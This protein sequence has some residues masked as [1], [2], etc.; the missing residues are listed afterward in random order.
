MLKYAKAVLF[1]LDGTLVDSMWMWKDIDMEYLGKYGITLPPELQ[2]YIEG[3]SFSEVSAYFKE[4]FG[5]KESLEEIKSEWV[6][7][8]KYKYTHEVPLK[9]GALRFL[10]HLKE[11]GIPMGIATSNSRDLLDAVLESLE[12]SP[13]FD[14]CMTSCEAGAGKPAPDI[15]LKVAKILKTEPKDCLIFEDTPAGILAGNRAGIPVC[16][17]ADENSAGRKE[18][19]LQMADYYAETFDQVLDRTYRNLKSSAAK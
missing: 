6:S 16:A 14:C 4:A 13:Y 9:P 11:Q 17:M 3:M 15:Y 5:I 8:A 18:Q 19:I 10:K 1:D 7:M 12:I 2:E